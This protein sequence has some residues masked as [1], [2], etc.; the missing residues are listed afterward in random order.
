MQLCQIIRKYL[1]KHVTFFI[2][3]FAGTILAEFLQKVA[4]LAAVTLKLQK[5][6]NLFSFF[7]W[8]GGWGSLFLED[9]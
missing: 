7:F 3:T 2:F 9:V 6:T 4:H 1:I 5:E 8:G